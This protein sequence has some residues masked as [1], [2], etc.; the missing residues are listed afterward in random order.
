MLKNVEFLV[1]PARIFFDGFRPPAF[2]FDIIPSSF[3]PYCL[4]FPRL[5]EYRI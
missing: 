3:N 4:I 1:L 5:V 2:Y